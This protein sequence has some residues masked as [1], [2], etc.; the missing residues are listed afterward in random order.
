MLGE[1]PET[2]I[3]PL[4][5]QIKES[6]REFVPRLSENAVALLEDSRRVALFLGFQYIDANHIVLARLFRE[7]QEASP[8]KHMRGG[9]LSFEALINKF[10]SQ[11][12]PVAQGAERAIPPSPTTLR[13]LRTATIWP[14][15][16]NQTTLISAICNEDIELKKTLN[17]ERPLTQVQIESVIKKIL[18]RIKPKPIFGSRTA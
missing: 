18:G 17:L 11:D 7:H 4:H 1:P 6:F 13:A 12:R 5:G 14:D 10:A 8:V 16:I 9:T 3:P 15:K 2:Q